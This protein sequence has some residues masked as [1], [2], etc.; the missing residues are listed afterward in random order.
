M[1]SKLKVNTGYGQFRWVVLLLTVAVI[2]PTVC[3][4]WFM[5]QAVKNERL[6]IRQ[7]LVNSYKNRL[8]ETARDVNEDWSRA[9]REFD[10]QQDATIYDQFIA[11][12]DLNRYDAV[13]IYDE[14]GRRLYPL[15]SGDIQSPSRVSEPFSDAWQ[16]EFVDADYAQA[17]RRYEQYAASFAGGISKAEGL[18]DGSDT[19]AEAAFLCF[20]AWIGQSRC[21]AR[22]GQID[23]ALQTCRQVAFSPLADGNNVA[24]LSLIANARL[25]MLSWMQ[26]RAQYTTMRNE[27]FTNLLTMLYRPNG[28]GISLPADQNLFVAEKAME[29]AHDAP[30]LQAEIQRTYGGKLERL[31]ASEEQSIRLAQQFPTGDAL[32]KWTSHVLHKLGQSED[33]G[34]A[35]VHRSPGRV[36]LASLSDAT[37]RSAMNV[38][39]ETF[40]DNLID[41]RISDEAKRPVMGSAG[42]AGEPFAASAIGT[43]FPG[44]T[45]ELFFKEGD[46]LDKAAGQNIAV[47]TW[48]GVL[49][50]LLILVFGA[51]A[52]KSVGRQV[53]INRLKND[54]IATV[55]HE[56]K[57]PLASMRV[58]VDTLLEGHYHDPAQATEYLQLVSRENER[59][60]RLIDNFLTF[61]RME[62]NK[63]A[64]RMELADPGTIARGAAEAVQTKFSKGACHFEMQIP[65][66]LPQVIADPDAM[67]TVLV[68]LL[69]NAYKYSYDEKYIRLDVSA[70]DGAV[71]FVV[72]DNGIG[73]PRRSLRKVFRRFY[74]VD[75]SLSRRTEGCGLGLSIAQFIVEAH[76][77]S[78]RADSK[79]GRG[80]T[81]TVTIPTAPT[82]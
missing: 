41:F 50:I 66:N 20:T 29:I 31:L 13:L 53:K 24:V 10:R 6:V 37:I 73:I 4:L 70:A 59:L 11:A 21:L 46:V 38:F 64:F 68:N 16:L 9:C 36:Y 51:A 80:S 69:D 18:G 79:P 48:T 76:N 47:Y 72:S 81:F 23:E 14:S 58:L 45:I 77:G 49:V 63:Q 78:V 5:G 40:Q 2:L 35:S 65:D 30:D 7:K 62:R 28:S 60:S 17:A 22:L 43:C 39:Q 67:V 8:E 42:P 34:Y 75:R 27:V 33:S 3:L 44:W 61:S 32:G 52:A 55:T 54:F 57:T 56:L 74:Q 1:R 26:G 25:L 71:R 82:V 19:D 15:L 12:T